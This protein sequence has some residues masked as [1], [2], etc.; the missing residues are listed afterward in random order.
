V[1]S[2]GPSEA[3][4]HLAALERLEHI[5]AAFASMVSH[6]T[7]TALVGIQ[8]WSELI[9]DGDLSMAE[10]RDYAWD[11][12]NEAQKIDSMIGEMFDLNR[13][14]SGQSPF[15][16]SRVHVD[17]VV[18][19]AAAKVRGATPEMTLVL[20]AGAG[21][22]TVLGDRDR[23]TQAVAKVLA[24]VV[25]TARP[26][27]VIALS[28]ATHA[29]WIDI[30]VRSTSWRVGDFEDWLY[31]RYER[32]EQRPSAILGAGLGLAIARAI[33]ELHRGEIKVLTGAEGAA[34]LRIRLPA[35]AE[36]DA[37]RELGRAPTP[38]R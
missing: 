18:E 32:Y 20:E 10:I 2:R 7:R 24:F 25:R 5:I 36:S 17:R 27:S 6:Q 26:G 15:R 38:S 33:I 9:R 13:L 4:R 8:G 14:E 16:M 28:T 37:A 19:D 29:N 21:P 35:L 3:E 34:E 22:S 12:F 23:L 1:S 11:I 30:T 31:G